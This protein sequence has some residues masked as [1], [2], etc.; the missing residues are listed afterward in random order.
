[1]NSWMQEDVE[2]G[3][4]NHYIKLSP[5]MIKMHVYNKGIGWMWEIEMFSKRKSSKVFYNKIE[6]I[7][8]CDTEAIELLKTAFQELWGIVI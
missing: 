6:C 4:G 2:F 8:A 3:I 7:V 1:M 5:P